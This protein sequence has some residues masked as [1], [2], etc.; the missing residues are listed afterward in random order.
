MGASLLLSPLSYLRVRS[1]V[2]VVVIVVIVLVLVIHWCAS[3]C[4][5]A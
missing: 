4:F 3:W 2:V 5:I 1:E